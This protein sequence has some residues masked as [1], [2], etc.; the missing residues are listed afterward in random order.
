MFKENKKWASIIVIM[1]SVF[2]LFLLFFV[3]YRNQDLPLTQFSFSK[4]GNILNLSFFSLSIIGI[5][6]YSFSKRIEYRKKMLFNFTI[7]ISAILILAS[8][9]TV[10][11]FP[12]PRIYLFDHPLNWILIGTLFFIF[13]FAQIFFII[14]IW[15]NIF[16]T[17]NLILTSAVDSVIV[18]ICLLI[19]TFLYSN[20]RER[21]LNLNNT[22]VKDNRVAV[23]LGAAV[24]SHNQPSPSL[25]A[26]LDKAAELYKDSVVN[27]IQLTGSNAPGELS[28]A[29]V[30]SNYLIK[31][32]IN[33]ANIWIEEKTTSTSQQIHYIKNELIKK[34]RI[35]NIILISAPY[36]LMRANEICKFYNMKVYLSASDITMSTQSKIY[37][38][39][40]ESVALLAFWLFAL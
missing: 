8:I 12:A 11:N 6:I 29:R 1:I 21:E 20:S 35:K 7:I 18:M 22:Q 17:E 10:I 19:F 24:W 15:L 34:K 28:E 30:A 38:N 16:N 27:Y 33:P 14:Y 36:H 32:E 37:N 40:R 39:I 9:S 3:K 5:I 2:D 26:R 13:Q 23:V 31:K 25:K 4:T